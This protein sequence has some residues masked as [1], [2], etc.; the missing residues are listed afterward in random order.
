MIWLVTACG[1]TARAAQR[2]R[3]EHWNHNCVFFEHSSL[4]P[5]TPP[6]LCR[7]GRARRVVFREPFQSLR[8]LTI[9][10]DVAARLQQN[11]GTENDGFNVESHI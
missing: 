5:T 2:V 11:N 7:S 1:A 9:H 8:R 4:I 6:A 3:K 10:T